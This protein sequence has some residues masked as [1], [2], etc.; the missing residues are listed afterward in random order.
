MP[1]LS[2]RPLRRFLALLPL[3]FNPWSASTSDLRELHRR[4]NRTPRPRISPLW[5]VPVIVSSVLVWPLWSLGLTLRLVRRSSRAVRALGGPRPLRQ[6]AELL[7][8]ANVHTVHPRDY[9]YFNL[10]RPGAR[11]E[12]ADFLADGRAQSIFAAINR[13]VD[14]STLDDKQTF[15][16]F[17]ANH[18]LGT[19]PILARISAG[20]AR[21][22]SSADALQRDLFVK[23]RGGAR[24]RDTARW[25]F[26]PVTGRYRRGG[27]SPALAWPEL[28]AHYEGLSQREEFL[29]QPR[30]R[31]HGAIADIGNGS[32]STIRL[33]TI[34]Q[35]D[36]TIREFA[37]MFNVPTRAAL[38]NNLADGGLAVAV[39]SARGVLRDAFTGAPGNPRFTRNP[40]N[41]APIAGRSLPCWRETVAL[42]EAAHARLAAIAIIGWDIA[43]TD[44]GPLI[45][46]GNHQISLNFHQLP[47]NGPFGRTAFPGLLLAQWRRKDASP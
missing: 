27:D 38:I 20:R 44:R 4:H 18:G 46:E 31:D 39:D 28:V 10:W 35:P 16:D 22:L 32:L 42:A 8:L 9:Y 37:S 29:V 25:T 45:L 47:P 43:I 13:G 23:P 15:H 19:P 7:W 33:I 36:G 17:C 41:G 1:R 40:F 34:V 26:D 24:A 2:R 5:R 30:L 12:A 6:A 11:A 3:H 14:T 21:L